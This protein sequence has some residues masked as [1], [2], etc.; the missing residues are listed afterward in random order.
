MT[1]A[2]QIA[3]RGIT[4]LVHF[5]TNVGLIGIVSTGKLLPRSSLSDELTLEYILRV[6]SKFRRDTAWLDHVNLSISRIN[7][8]FFEQSEAWH[9][10]V[11]WVLLSFDATLMTHDGVYFTTTNNIYPACRRGDDVTAFDA[12]FADEVPARYS[13]RIRR[14]LTHPLGW[15]TCPQAEV[16]Y[17]GAVSLEHLKAIYVRTED[18]EHVVHAILAA[19]GEP[20]LPVIL[21]PSKF[22]AV[23]QPS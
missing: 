2:D 17:P 12:M 10:D 5:T 23:Q 14:A 11:F 19:V 21:D 13:Q 6:N 20:N 7:H 18:E 16:L 8:T 3:A 9:N 22:I 1:V 15:T 4:D